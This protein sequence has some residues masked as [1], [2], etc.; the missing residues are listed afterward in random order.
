MEIDVSGGIDVAG[1]HYSVECD[2]SAQEACYASGNLGQC[3][4]SRLKIE[5][6]TRIHRDRISET[7]IHETL[8]AVKE[9]YDKSLSHETLEK[10]SE[11]LYQALKSLGINFVIKKGG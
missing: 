8:E 9:H 4:P 2:V 11:G 1:F 10:I 3:S 6:D 7:F 5:I